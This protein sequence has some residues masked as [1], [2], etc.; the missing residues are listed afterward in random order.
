MI[1]PV[2]IRLPVTT[3]LASWR[4]DQSVHGVGWSSW[5]VFTSASTLS[6]AAPA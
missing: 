4:T 3:W 5:A 1:M 6:I 2:N